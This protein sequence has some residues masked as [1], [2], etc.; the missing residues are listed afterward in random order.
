LTGSEVRLFSFPLPPFVSTVVSRS[1][2][3]ILPRGSSAFAFAF[4]F[5]LV[6]PPSSICT[7][8]KVELAELFAFSSGVIAIW[9]QSTFCCLSVHTVLGMLLACLELG[10]L[11]MWVSGEASVIEKKDHVAPFLGS[12]K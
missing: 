4:T 5:A 1:V 11:K 7:F 10:N 6:A 2:V 3:S 9:V 12:F 8:L